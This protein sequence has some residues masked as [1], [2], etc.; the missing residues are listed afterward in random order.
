MFN[1]R[2][3]Q[4]GY[5]V[6]CAGRSRNGGFVLIL[7]L[8]ML[9][10]LTLIGVSSMDSANIELKATA[11]AR[12]HQVAFNATQSLLEFAISKPVV[13]DKLINYQRNDPNDPPQVYNSFTF[14]GAKDLVATVSLIGCSVA[15]GSSLEEGKGFSFSYFKVDG[16]AA[17]AKGTAR[18][19][20]S[21]AVRYPAAGCTE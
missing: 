10:A 4:L 21:Q 20:Q 19:F 1:S 2:K 18:S 6:S 9:T 3:R 14:P 7:A 13:A 12:Q 17:N 16:Q 8:V 11:N 15:V 5:S